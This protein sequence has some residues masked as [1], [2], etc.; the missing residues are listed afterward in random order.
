MTYAICRIQK[1]KSSNLQASHQHAT[2]QR[3]TPNA[4]PD[5]ANIC[6]LGDT[7]QELETVVRERIGSQTIRKNAVMAVQILLSASP[8]FFRPD[9]KSEWGYYEAHK[10]EAFQT[11]AVD[12][13]QESY[14]NRIVRAD[15]HLD[16]GTP[17]IHA[18]LYPW[19]RGAN[20]TVGVSLA[21][22]LS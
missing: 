15:L 3:F 12:W 10:L 14:G 18:F 5:K 19:T 20:S 4:D 7:N 8:E 22:A 17:H 13:L 9:D 6:L 1:L 21:L 11:V 2:R 16:E